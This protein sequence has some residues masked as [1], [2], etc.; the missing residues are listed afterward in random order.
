MG[1]AEPKAARVTYEEAQMSKWRLQVTSPNL[2]KGEHTMWETLKTVAG[3]LLEK[4]KK[5]K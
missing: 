2:N 5:T 4:K 1:V 3:Q